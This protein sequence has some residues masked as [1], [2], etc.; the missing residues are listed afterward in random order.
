MV[1]LYKHSLRITRHC[2]G[3]LTLGAA[4]LRSSQ[5]HASVVNK[6]LSPKS[7]SK[8]KSKYLTLNSNKV[9]VLEFCA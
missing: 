7:K 1:L 8:S 6:H 2:K 4:F 9:Q 5:V 3:L